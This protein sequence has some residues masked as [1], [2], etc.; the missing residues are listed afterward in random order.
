VELAC[1][2]GC[3]SKRSL[4]DSRG[5]LGSELKRLVEGL[6][7]DLRPFFRPSLLGKVVAVD[8]D[9][10]R[11]D[12]VVGAD[13]DAG[14]AGLAL[15]DI[16]VASLFAQDG[17][18]I[19]ALPEVD[20]EVT[21]SFHDGD[22]TKP[23][24]EAP[25]FYGN[26]APPG[27]TT[28]TIAIRGKQG[29]KIEMKPGTSEIIISAGS[30][31]LIPTD[32]RQEHTTGDASHIVKGAR[33]AQVVGT[34]SI[35]ADTWKVIVG[36]AATIE[37]GSLSEKTTGDLVQ[38]VGGSLRQVVAGSVSQQVAGGVSLSTLFSKREIVGDGYEIL[39]I[40][41][42]VLDSAGGQ[43]DIGAN[44]LT[45]PLFINIGSTASG[46]VQLGGLGA[47]GQPAACGIP[48]QTILAN[49]INVLKTVPL[50]IGNLGVPIAP[51]PA[52]TAALVAADT[53]MLQLL[54]GKVFI[55]P[56]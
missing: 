25:I 56:V 46:P 29:Q 33:D 19:W 5:D 16:P 50:G 3:G 9:N 45:P 39:V 18:G 22:V 14:E 31:K 10:Y 53:A 48:L 36:R 32:R 20:A 35:Q 28:G 23:Y 24:V 4:M 34:D 11:V 47:T 41:D 12:V 27:F 42:L 2:V 49:L 52:V 6:H 54:S 44:L 37:A 43:I 40:G 1:V 30:L 26:K 8:D 51:N 38:E 15:P 17:Y 7:P 55:G 21:V 13:E